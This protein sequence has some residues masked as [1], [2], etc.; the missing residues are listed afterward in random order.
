[1]GY[2]QEISMI[3]VDTGYWKKRW[4]DSCG[5][6]VFRDSFSAMDVLN[7]RF[8]YNRKNDENFPISFDKTTFTIIKNRVSGTLDKKM[9]WAAVIAPTQ[10]FFDND[11]REYAPRGEE[12]KELQLARLISDKKHVEH[13]PK[14]K[15]DRAR[16]EAGDELIKSGMKSAYDKPAEPF[17]PKPVVKTK[18]YSSERNYS[19]E[20]VL[21]SLEDLNFE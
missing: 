4:D 10:A 20:E 11:W 14:N 16:M 19:E 2:N 18:K 5:Y 1:M 3:P 12:F 9:F 13:L 7:A 6:I 15:R 8:R 17:I 21:E